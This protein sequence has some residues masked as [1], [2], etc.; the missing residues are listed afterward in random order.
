MDGGGSGM[1]EREGSRDGCMREW[2][3]GEKRV[4]DLDGWGNGKKVRGWAGV[5][6]MW[7]WGE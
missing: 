3:G 1:R 4:R 6:W 5:G 2:D 7:E